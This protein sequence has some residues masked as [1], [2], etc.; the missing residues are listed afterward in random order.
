MAYMEYTLSEQR[1]VKKKK[2]K[3]KPQPFL[4]Y[5]PGLVLLIVWKNIIAFSANYVRFFLFPNFLLRYV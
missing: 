4:A 3:K 2:K 5:F 1:C